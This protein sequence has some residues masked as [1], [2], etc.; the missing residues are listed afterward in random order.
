MP[1]ELKIKI[2][3]CI[4]KTDACTEITVRHRFFFMVFMNYN[5]IIFQKKMFVNEFCFVIVKC[6]KK[7]LSVEKNLKDGIIKGNNWLGENKRNE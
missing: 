6:R 4:E 2:N 5:H 3:I 7:L 1:P